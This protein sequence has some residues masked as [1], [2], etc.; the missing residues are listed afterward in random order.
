M[1][2]WEGKVDHI[3]L[4]GTTQLIER[5][6]LQNL[7]MTDPSSLGEACGGGKGASLRPCLPRLCWVSNRERQRQ[8]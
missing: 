7:Q 5:L 4:V 1:V 6:A 2:E 8:G 3:L